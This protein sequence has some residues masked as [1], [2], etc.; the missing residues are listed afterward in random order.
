MAEKKKKEEKKKVVKKTTPK[1]NVPKKETKKK[2]EEK[3]KI[4]SLLVLKIVFCLLLILVIVLSIVVIKK[5]KELSEKVN[6]NIV[7]P[8]VNKEDEAPFSI[9]VQALQKEG[10]YIFRLANFKSAEV[11]SEDLN[12]F[13]DLKNDSTCKVSLTEYGS[14]KNLLDNQKESHI[15]MGKVPKDKQESIYYVVKTSDC[16]KITKKDYISVKVGTVKGE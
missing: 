9:N 12:Y 11:N 15:E 8:I 3:K 13:I 4:D 2:V 7:I 16:G 14:N 6:A 1:K 5:K 10:Q